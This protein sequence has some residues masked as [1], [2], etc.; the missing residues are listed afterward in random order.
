MRPAFVYSGELGAFSER[1]SCKMWIG[2]E[3]GRHYHMANIL[4]ALI[5]VAICCLGHAFKSVGVR[6]AKVASG[7]LV[8]KAVVMEGDSEAFE[9][10]TLAR[11]ATKFFDEK[12]VPEDVLKQVLALVLRAPSGFNM[13][14]Y[15]CIV[16]TSDEA[17]QKL[18][19]GMLGSNQ[20][21]VLEAG[22]SV[23]FAADL[24]SMK[25]MGKLTTL[26]AEA[27]EAP[28]FIR[29]VPLY[30]SLFS[31]GHNRLVRIPMTIFKKIAFGVI[32]RL[33]KGMPTIAGAETWA[34][35][36]TMLAVQ[37]LLLA[38][39]AH[40]LASCPMEGFDMR[41]LRKQFRIP[42]RYSIPIVVSIGYASEEKQDAKSL[43]FA[44]EEV[45]HRED[46]GI[47]MEG[48]PKL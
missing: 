39:T 40:G 13:Q 47:P 20:Q 26:L 28:E 38:A 2:G 35:K 34:F 23:I 31:T 43:R 12:P 33:G 16:V 5:F 1:R 4:R 24:N 3:H 8:A 44:P 15:Q 48:I 46:F 45:Y 27:G 41:R 42:L 9:R 32:R 17:K 11:C 18:S 7:T 25:N 37:E 22:A 21:R 19:K 36:N 6:T 30:A 14:P 29:K 10:I